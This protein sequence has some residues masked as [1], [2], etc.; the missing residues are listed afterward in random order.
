VPPNVKQ[1]DPD[2]EDDDEATPPSRGRSRDDDADVPPRKKYG[3]TDKTNGGKS[4]KDGEKEET[5]GPVKAASVGLTLVDL[6]RARRGEFGYSD[7]DRG[8]LISAVAGSGP[9]VGSG[10]RRGMLIVRV[11]GIVVLNAE[12]A[13]DGISKGNLNDGIRLRVRDTFGKEQTITLRQ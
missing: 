7:D 13:L 8:A 9:T 5:K 4:K 12:E 10:L 6:T 11:N 2:E 1:R 3:G